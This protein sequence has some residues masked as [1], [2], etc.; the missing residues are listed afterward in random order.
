MKRICVV[1]S[2]LGGLF[3]M[4]SCAGAPQ[5]PPQYD[6]GKDAIRLR[7]SADTQLNSCQGSPHTLLICVYQLGDPNAFNQLTADEDGLYKLLECRRFDPSVTN[8]KRIIVQPGQDIT[9]TL[10]RAEG[11]KYVGLVAGYYQIEKDHMI[12]LFKIPLVKERAGTFS[13]KVLKT[14]VLDVELLLGPEKIRDAGTLKS[15]EE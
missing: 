1:L 6:F 3:M 4:V 14:G 11:T 5:A 7:F 10:D 8:V 9:S 13:K 2:I 15:G 12:R